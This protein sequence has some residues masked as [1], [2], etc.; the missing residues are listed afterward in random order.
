MRSLYLFFWTSIFFSCASQDKGDSGQHHQSKQVKPELVGDFKSVI[1]EELDLDPGNDSLWY[2]L[3]I[4]IPGD[5]HLAVAQPT[6]D[7]NRRGVRFQ[8][9]KEGQDSTFHCETESSPGFDSA[10]LYPSFF[11]NDMGQHIIL[12]DTGERDSW[13]QKVYLLVENKFYDL[14]FI[15]VGSVN[16]DEDQE[17]LEQSLSPQSIAKNVT[18]SSDANGYRFTFDLEEFVLYDDQKGNLNQIVPSS[19]WSYFLDKENNWTLVE[20]SL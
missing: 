6:S 1:Y 5:L 14:G 3:V 20:E 8:L 4:D 13:G 19:Q 17:T 16:Y 10:K 7:D 18:I 11:S 12:A 9:L 2:H 15:D